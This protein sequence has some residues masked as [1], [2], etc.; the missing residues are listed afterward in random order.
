MLLAHYSCWSVGPTIMTNRTKVS[1][2]INN[3]YITRTVAISAYQLN[4][5]V[6]SITAATFLTV[7]W[8][9]TSPIERWRIVTLPGSLWPNTCSAAGAP[10]APC[11]PTAVNGRTEVSYVGKRNHCKLRSGRFH[12]SCSNPL[13]TGGIITENLLDPGLRSIIIIISSCI[14]IKF[15]RPINTYVCIKQ[16][17]KFDFIP[18]WNVKVPV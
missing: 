16:F 13:V 7:A 17:C 9:L 2:M 10:V 1:I 15:Q 4:W 18:D 8:T 12:L 5:A 14:I 6:L 3:K 11:P